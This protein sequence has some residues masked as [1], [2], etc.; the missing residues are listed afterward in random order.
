MTIIIANN[1]DNVYDNRRYVL[2]EIIGS[3]LGFLAS[4][5][6]KHLAGTSRPQEVLGLSQSGALGCG[7]GVTD[8]SMA[9]PYSTGGGGTHFKARVAASYLAATFA[10]APA[11]GVPGLFVIEVLTQRAAFG[12]PLDDL[13]ISGQLAD[14]TRSKLHL[15]VKNELAFTEN[16]SAWVSTLQQAWDTFNGVFDDTKDRLCASFYRDQLGRHVCPA[17]IRAGGASAPDSAS[18]E[19]WRTIGCPRHR[20]LAR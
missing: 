3:F 5:S 7:V 18:P 6:L 1:G 12:D 16:D 11:R 4:H 10:E 9:S 2:S 15:Q 19:G 20:H 14:G 8:K 13:V 17:V